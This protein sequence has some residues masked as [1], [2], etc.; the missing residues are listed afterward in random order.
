[1][2]RHVVDY[3]LKFSAANFVSSVGAILLGITQLLLVYIIKCMRSGPKATGQVWE[4]AQGL[5]FTLPSPP[6]YHTFET[7]PS[8]K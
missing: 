2:P 3:A 8:V 5:E 6:P 4:G 7:Q 1:M